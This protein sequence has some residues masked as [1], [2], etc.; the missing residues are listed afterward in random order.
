MWGLRPVFV[1]KVAE[2]RVTTA[3]RRELIQLPKKNS[4]GVDEAEQNKR[5]AVREFWKKSQFI[6]N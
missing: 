2:T 5:T 3:R 6:L 4:W 1:L